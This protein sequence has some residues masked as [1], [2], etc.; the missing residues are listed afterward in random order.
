MNVIINRKQPTYDCGITVDGTPLMLT[1][2]SKNDF[3]ALTNLGKNS[4]LTDVYE[5]V[6]KILNKN[7]EHIV[8]PQEDVDALDY[9][10][11]AELLKGYTSFLRGFS[12]DPN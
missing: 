4:K 11:V 3:D 9:I 5:F 8:I 7:T 12:S 1:A 2:V 6:G 10:T